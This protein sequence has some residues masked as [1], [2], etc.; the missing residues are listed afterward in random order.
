[1]KYFLL[2]ISLFLLTIGVHS[3]DFNT[4]FIDKTLRVDYIFTGDAVS[5]TVSLEQLN[6]LPK[7]AGRRHSFGGLADEYFYEN[8]TFSDT[9]PFD[10]EPWEPNITTLVDFKSKWNN[11][12][13]E[14]TPVPTDINLAE[15]YPLGV[16]EGAGYSSKGIYRPAIDCRMKT[17]T[18][19]D[20]CPACQSALEQLIK[21]Y[22]E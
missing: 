1:M 6:Q 15:K 2:T 10:I 4:Y 9:Y 18:C 12:L 19:R 11:I 14:G 16:F 17:N 3:Q 22:T 13:L 8:D 7:W 21:F 5:Q 20:F